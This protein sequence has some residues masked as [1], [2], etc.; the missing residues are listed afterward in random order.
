MSKKALGTDALADNQRE[1]CLSTNATL[2][3]KHILPNAILGVQTSR[4][5]KTRVSEA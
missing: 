1:V 2:G 4:F 3:T 5:E